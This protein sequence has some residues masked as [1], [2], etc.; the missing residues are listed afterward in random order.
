MKKDK[1]KLLSYQLI[2]SFLFIISILISILLTYNQKQELLN[3]KRI[4]NK[5][6]S[7][8]LNLFNRIFALSIIFAILY[9]NYSE[10]QINKNKRSNIAPYKHQVYASIFSVISAIIVLYVVIENW[11][12]NPNI[13]SIENPII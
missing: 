3:E 2:T 4:L 10:Y 7:K 9:I 8:Y 13:T 5:K 6:S 12:D 11:E 1:I